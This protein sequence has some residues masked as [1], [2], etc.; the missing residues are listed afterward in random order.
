MLPCR[1][2]NSGVRQFFFRIGDMRDHLP[3]G[4]PNEAMIR[5]QPEVTVWFHRDF[6]RLTGGQVKHAH[7][8]DHVRRFAGYGPRIHFTA[9]LPGTSPSPDQNRLWPSGK[10]FRTPK[11]AP[12]QGD[13]FFLAGL[14]WRHLVQTGLDALP[15]PR[16]NLVQHV[17]HADP[18]SELRSYLKK[19]AVRICVSQEVADAI[20]A[21][22]RVNGPVFTIPNAVDVRFQGPAQRGFGWRQGLQVWALAQRRL[23]APVTTIVGYKRPDL[24][25]ALSHSLDQAGIRHHLLVGFQ[26]RHR[27]LATL[28]AST[29]VVCL[30]HAKEGFYLPALEAMASNCVAVT[31]DCIGNRGFCRHQSN[32]LIAQP[33]AESLT[34]TVQEALGQPPETRNAMLSQARQTAQRHSLAAER[35]QF[36]DLLTAIRNIW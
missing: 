14:D 29:V 27:F 24:A 2:A 9:N 26:P 36:H 12:R 19:R 16:I 22:G 34:A 8:F 4:L 10:A 6:D 31:L 1:H 15:N 35:A 18:G 3:C 23:Q 28:V 13:V 32:C 30:P 33:T 20:A 11:W 5:S 21:T 7:Y 17:R 25:Q